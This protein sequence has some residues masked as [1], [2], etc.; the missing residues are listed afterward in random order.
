MILLGELFAV[1][2][3]VS[4]SGSSF[5]FAEA[6]ERTGSV[7]LNVNRIIIAAILLFFT[8][9]LFNFNYNISFYQLEFLAISGVVGIVL[10]D[11]F[12]FSAFKKIGARISMLMMS[13]VPVISAVLAFFFLDEILSLKVMIGIFITLSGIALVVFASDKSSNAKYKITKIGLF[14]GFLG[15]V[16]QATGLILAK[17][18]FNSG[19]LN[20]FVATFVRIF[21]SAIVILPF[22]ILI[23]KYK[24]P[25][26]LYKKDPKA[27]LFT[28]IGTVFGPF[29]GITLSLLAIKYTKVGIA[30]TLM[31]TV[32][33]LMLPMAKYIH[34]EKFN[35]KII[36]GT[37]IAVGGVAVIFLR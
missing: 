35:W 5:A 13:L 19:E 2:T 15:A 3:A 11:T 31:S 33:I 10:G 37:F 18:A 29:L 12:L 24:N 4:W 1:L 25:I 27:L 32:P 28:F 17:E 6:A 22:T 34:K 16:G 30:T 21:A 23:K 20:E 7:Q 8:V 14:F 36:L 9:I 26:K